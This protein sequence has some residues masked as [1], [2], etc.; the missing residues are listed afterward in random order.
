MKITIEGTD[1]E[2]FAFMK[3][4]VK[5]SMLFSTENLNPYG[6]SVQE[7]T[8]AAASPLHFKPGER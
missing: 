5:S 7:N 4:A 8:T 6:H 2:I 1:A 3:K